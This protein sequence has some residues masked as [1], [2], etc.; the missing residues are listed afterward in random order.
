MNP[1]DLIQWITGAGPYAVTVVVLAWLWLE[2]KER[3]AVQKSE[4]GLLNQ[5]VEERGQSVQ[6][7]AEFGE[8]MRER[9]RLH[10]EALG[11]TLA[12]LDVRGQR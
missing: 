4:R 2:R 1:G 9:L 6:A 7:M 10:D 5:L 3:V 11:K 12:V 8:A